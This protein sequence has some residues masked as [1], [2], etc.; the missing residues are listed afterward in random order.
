MSFLKELSED[1][2]A[3]TLYKYNGNDITVDSEI[4][5]KDV[6]KSSDYINICFIAILCKQILSFYILANYD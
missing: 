3:I 4:S 5:I 6:D 1:K 2:Q